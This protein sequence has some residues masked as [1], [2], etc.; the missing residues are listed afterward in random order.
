[1]NTGR[2]RFK[3]GNKGGGR[4]PIPDEL[5]QQ[6]SEAVPDA[7]KRLKELAKSKDEAIALKA[8]I[9]LINREFGKPRET[10]AVLGAE[11]LPLSIKVEVI[12]KK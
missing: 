10:H 6:L 3:K 7:I 12:E 2:T 1:M 9:Y 11:G 8:S 4:K 5:K